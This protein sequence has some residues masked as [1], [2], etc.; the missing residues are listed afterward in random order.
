MPCDFLKS[1]VVF[2]KKTYKPIFMV[3]DDDFDGD[4]GDRIF[5]SSKR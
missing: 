3:E 4:A 2:K 1:T 5:L